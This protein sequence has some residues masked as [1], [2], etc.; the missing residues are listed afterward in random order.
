MIKKKKR[1]VFL[2]KETTTTT[3][4]SNIWKQEVNLSGTQKLLED[5]EWWWTIRTDQREEAS[6]STAIDYDQRKGALHPHARGGCRQGLLTDHRWW[7][8]SHKDASILSLCRPARADRVDIS[9]NRIH[10]LERQHP[11]S[12]LAPGR[13]QA[14]W[15][16]TS[17]WGAPSNH[18]SPSILPHWKLTMAAAATLPHTNTPEQISITKTST[19]FRT[20]KHVRK[21]YTTKRSPKFSR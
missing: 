1:W 12:Q 2:K 6:A 19:P 16:Y 7:V 20:I 8:R 9:G 11:G 15:I 21:D 14:L 3:Q 13:D 18:A 4:H 17:C 10:G 5:T